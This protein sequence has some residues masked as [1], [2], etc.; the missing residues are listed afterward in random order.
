MNKLIEEDI[1]NN[2]AWSHRYFCI[3]GHDEL[4]LL[5]SPSNLNPKNPT[6]LRRK[7]LF[8]KRNGGARDDEQGNLLAV[9]GDVRDR[10][11]TH[12]K[13]LIERAPM[14][15]SAWNYLRG[16]VRR[17]DVPFTSLLPFCASF[18]RA[19]ESGSETKAETETETQTEIETE[20]DFMADT[21]RS[22]HAIAFLADIYA[23]RYIQS[24][25]EGK[26]DDEAREMAKRAWESLAG[27][28]DGIRRNYWVWRAEGLVE[29]RVGVG[30]M[31]E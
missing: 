8:T 29:G 17:C 9:D 22:S 23:A 30:I 25:K 28:W 16:V 26:P 3:F 31:E 27:K 19:K 24:M 21:V 2:S 20:L 15:L 1:Y 6:P 4:S 11:V 5:E 7:D 10:E 12:T 13:H 18:V 14:N